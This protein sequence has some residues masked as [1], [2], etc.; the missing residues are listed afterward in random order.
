MLL[1]GKLLLL[2]AGAGSTKLDT[3]RSLDLLGFA[4][5]YQFTDK[6]KSE[7][8]TLLEQ[9]EAWVDRQALSLDLAQNAERI[10]G[11]F[12]SLLKVMDS[13]YQVRGQAVNL[14]SLCRMYASMRTGGWAQQ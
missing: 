9:L 10:S 8:V 12:D 6:M 3:A 4:A 1:D 14:D 5:S 13:L 7:A 11:N 2:H